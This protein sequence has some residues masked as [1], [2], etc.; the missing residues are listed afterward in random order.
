MKS[1]WVGQKRGTTFPSAALIA[2]ND[3][4]ISRRA[5]LLQLYKISFLPL[6]IGNCEGQQVDRKAGIARRHGVR[7]IEGVRRRVVCYARNT[8]ITVRRRGRAAINT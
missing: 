5:D 1:I 7:Q 6:Q 8:P 2:Y 3:F 4:N